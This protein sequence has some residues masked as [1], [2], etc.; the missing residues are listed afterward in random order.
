M[1]SKRKPGWL[2]QQMPK[3]A[4]MVD[5]RRA[6]WGEE[7]VKLCIADGLKGVPDR[8]YAFENGCIVGTGFSA[9][10]SPFSDADLLRI[11][12]LSGTSYMVMAQPKGWVEPVEEGVACGQNSRR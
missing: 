8:F 3:V 12:S 5:K 9:A 6:Q 4:D 2:R 1:D 11:A 10:L 7:H